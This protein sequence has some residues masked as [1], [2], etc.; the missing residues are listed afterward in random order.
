MSEYLTDAAHALTFGF[1]LG[2]LLGV[3][4]MTLVGQFVR[5]DLRYRE[6]GSDLRNESTPREDGRE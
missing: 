6:H 2:I 4:G 1:T 3:S 5:G